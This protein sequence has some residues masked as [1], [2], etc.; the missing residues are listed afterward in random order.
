[1]S[2]IRFAKETAPDSPAA[3][4]VYFYIDSADGK[5]K[6]KDENGVVAILNNPDSINI[7]DLSDG[8]AGQL[9]T[10]G[11]DGTATIIE[12][13][14]ADHILT[15]NGI[16]LAPEFKVA[17]AGFEDPMTTVGDIIF[18]NASNETARLP[19]GTIG[20]VLKSD[21]TDAS[22][23]NEQAGFADPLTT[24]GDV[25]LKDASNV[26]NRL[27]IGTVGQVL[28]SDGTDASW[29]DE[30]EGF[31]DPLTTRGDMMY[32]DSSNDTIRLSI[33]T[34]G[35]VLKSDG[36]D[37]SWENE[38]AGFADP[39]T[40]R[41]DMMYRDS[42]N[43]TNRLPIGTNQQV[44]M[45]D[46]TDIAMTDAKNFTVEMDALS[47]TKAVIYT[48]IRNPEEFTGPFSY[49]NTGYTVGLYEQIT[50]A[51]SASSASFTKV[52]WNAWHRD[53]TAT[54]T[55]RVYVRGSASSF[56]WGATTPDATM[57]YGPGEFPTSNAPTEFILPV[58][59]DINTGQFVILL[60]TS[61][62]TTSLDVRITRWVDQ[63]VEAPF[64]HSFILTASTSSLSFG[65]PTYYS[66]GLELTGI[67]NI[68]TVDVVVYE[69][70]R[71]DSEVTGTNSYGY[72]GSST[73]VLGLRQTCDADFSFIKVK[74][75]MW[76][77]TSEA[78]NLGVYIRNTSGEFDLGTV[79]PD[80]LLEFAAGEFPAA[81]GS[82][83]F[84]FGTSMEVTAGQ[85][86]FVLLLNQGVGTPHVASFIEESASEP[87]RLSWIL[88]N[89]LTGIFSNASPG[90]YWGAGINFYDEENAPLQL[91][92][93]LNNLP[94]GSVQ[95]NGYSIGMTATD[96][97]SAIKEIYA[98]GSATAENVTYDDSTTGIGDN[99]QDALDAIGGDSTSRIMLP[100]EITAVVD[101]ELQIFTRGVF[102]SFDPY[103]QPTQIVCTKGKAYP[104]Y[105]D[106]TAITADVGTHTFTAR[107]LNNLGNVKTTDACDLV[108]VEA[109]G[110]PT[111]NLNILCVGD[112]LTG[113]GG[114]IL[115]CSRRLLDSIGTGTPAAL[116]YSNISFIGDSGTAPRQW[117]GY[118]G[119]TW[120]AF[121]G[122][123][124]VAYWI[125]D[126]THDKVIGDDQHSYYTDSNSD[127]WELEAIDGDDIKF[128]PL[129]SQTDMPTAPDT[130]V[131]LSGGVHTTTISYTVETEEPGT[132][133]WDN[134]A[135][136]FSFSAFMDNY[137]FAGED[138]DY[139]CVLLGWNEVGV[140]SKIEVGDHASSIA[141]ARIFIDK[142]H[143][144]YPSCVVRVM[145]I[146]IPSVN[147]GL[148]ANYGAGDSLANYWR[149]VK[150]ANSLNIEYQN[151][152]NE[153]AYS[154]YCRFISNA[155][156]FD[157]EWNMSYT[158][159]TVN[160]RSAITEN[161]G[162]N[163]VHPASGGYYQIGDAL[164]RDIIRT[165]CSD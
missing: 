36:T 101:D 2:K 161:I 140:P 153:V 39:L 15:S 90:S 103:A 120:S 12:V 42:S 32:R 119:W 162:T 96:V 147:G 40:T 21:G 142:L 53:A 50:L 76:D 109:T 17:P 150:C 67:T 35:Q 74:V 6:V 20:Q 1:M 31:A 123:G 72:P 144:D 11:T 88:G 75:N 100:D 133:F 117:V 24:R 121:I 10:W 58:A 86:V 108:V 124:R 55:M 16:G 89:S 99:V 71:G 139:C 112:S 104:R 23:E 54:V 18:K 45:S 110:Q 51:D 63:A 79:E 93:V 159:A 66:G 114:W 30:T 137:G 165:F 26:T 98:S 158:T 14:T 111:S 29:D 77:T 68:D 127:R 37:V 81:S 160:T 85:T 149:T 97:D 60:I 163:G 128:N 105:W 146:Q 94:A 143:A 52:K 152:C 73:P 151:L 44:P 134:T 43:T 132:P 141:N 33:G 47:F 115:E 41:G 9:I 78:I 102:E 3:D 48:H 156:Q 130:L 116:G 59:V 7:S 4:K 157:S 56:D 61:S 83:I 129:D 38:Q 69:H 113:G 80:G 154:S 91:E 82:T 8:I 46:G 135:G 106:Y 164:Y 34:N 126:T 19:V 122:T 84:D 118:G 65:S 125:T 27:P 49:G 138:I 95:F 136:E 28:K 25:M 57:V 87:Y 13:G 64:R 70:P 62:N 131:W 148:A 155:V 107:Y 22:W 145:G 5:I 92:F